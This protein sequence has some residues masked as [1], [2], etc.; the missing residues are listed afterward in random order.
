MAGRPTKI[1]E[2]IITKIAGYIRA[3]NYIETASAVV[4]INKSTLYDWLKRGAREPGTLF[5]QFSDAVKKAMAESEVSDLNVISK[6]AMEGVWQAA[7]WRL[8]RKFPTKFGRKISVESKIVEDDDEAAS[9]VEEVVLRS[10]FGE[11]YEQANLEGSENNDE[12]GS[13][14]DSPEP[15][16]DTLHSADDSQDAQGEEIIL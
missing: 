13:G 7:A 5:E 9:Q 2:E 12:S 10:I 1:N 3:G 8:E 11:E 16:P 15:S 6:A 14:E 4:G